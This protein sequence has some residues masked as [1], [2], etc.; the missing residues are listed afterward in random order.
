MDTNDPSLP[1]KYQ[2]LLSEFSKLK[3][4]LILLNK[5]LTEEQNNNKLLQ[6]QLTEQDRQLKQ[7]REESDGREFRNQQ[8]SRRVSVLQVKTIQLHQHRV[9]SFLCQDELKQPQSASGPHQDDST[10]SIFDAELSSKITEISHLHQN[11]Q[12]LTAENESLRETNTA[13]LLRH[14]DDQCMI[15][16]QEDVIQ[17]QKQLI[18]DMSQSLS[19]AAAAA[20]PILSDNESNHNIEKYDP[21]VSSYLF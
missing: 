15:K 8:L 16:K 6:Q 21:S 2:K 5:G 12:S 7:L 3:N 1:G 19:A 10:F 4:Q 14:T 17:Q 18:D 11:V 20:V 9:I 13:I